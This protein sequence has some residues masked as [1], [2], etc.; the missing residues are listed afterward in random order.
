MV[1]CI[2]NYNLI[3]HLK[4]QASSESHKK[5]CFNRCFISRGLNLSLVPITLV[6]NALDALIGSGIGVAAI[7]TAGAHKEIASL[8]GTYL[9]RSNRL[10]AEPFYQLLKSI[11]PKASFSNATHVLIPNRGNGFISSLVLPKLH[12]EGLK[13]QCSTNV[14]E[15]HVISRL[16]FALAGL[17]AIVTRIADATI[18]LP[19]VAIALMTY[20]KVASINNLAYRTLQSL[21][22]INDL[23][24]SLI[25]T[26]NPS[27]SL[28]SQCVPLSS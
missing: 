1:R 2:S 8:A 12:E 18:A 6:T 22:L 21:G 4:R 16:T 28:S 23:F 27:A 17:A 14:F 26:L 10:L 15:R 13:C 11:N 19:A 3:Q 9:P 20:G 5:N 25:K 7:C 24:S